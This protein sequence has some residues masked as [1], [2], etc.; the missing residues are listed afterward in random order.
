MAIKE[1]IG[2][3][4]V[5]EVLN[6]ALGADEEGV[7]ALMNQRV[8]CNEVLEADPTIQVGSY[9][10]ERSGEKHCSVGVLGLLNG[11]F[12]IDEDGWGP[13]AAVYELRCVAGCLDSPAAREK[14]K[15]AASK[16]TPCPVCK[17]RGLVL[18]RIVEF[19]EVDDESKGKTEAAG[20]SDEPEPDD[21]PGRDD[22]SL[23]P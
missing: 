23:A 17:V 14:H 6:R 19:R 11:L 2:V 18:G 16:G 12:G 13:I 3:E 21:E 5:L 9:V 10:D 7:T 22:D 15:E 4:E 1:F 20:D 8:P